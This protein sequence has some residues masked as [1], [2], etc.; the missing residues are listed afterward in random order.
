MSGLLYVSRPVPLSGRA[1]ARLQRGGPYRGQ[2]LQPGGAEYPEDRL[3]LVVV[4][5]GSDDDTTSGTPVV[6]DERVALDLVTTDALGKPQDSLKRGART[7]PWRLGARHRCRCAP[8]AADA[9][10]D[11]RTRE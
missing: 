11:G 3:R 4:D 6:E 10:A 1:R 9:P 5:G 7:V 2:A 8:A